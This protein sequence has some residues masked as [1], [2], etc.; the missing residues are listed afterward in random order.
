M[1][2]VI[3]IMTI[4]MVMMTIVMVVTML[5]M[6]G[7]GEGNGDGVFSRGGTKDIDAL[8]V[9]GN[10]CNVNLCFVCVLAHFGFWNSKYGKL[11]IQNLQ[12]G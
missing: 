2:M 1:V 12:H 10:E 6:M 11:I 3:I 9:H 8:R 5:V 4:V 7:D